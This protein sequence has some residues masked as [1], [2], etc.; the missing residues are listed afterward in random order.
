MRTKRWEGGCRGIAAWLLLAVVLALSAGCAPP[1]YEAYRA[2]RVERSP[3]QTS[4]PAADSRP[5]SAPVVREKILRDVVVGRTEAAA[6]TVVGS[7]GSAQPQLSAALNTLFVRS[8]AGVAL[9]NQPLQFGRPFRSGEIA[10]CPQLTLDGEPIATQADVKTRYDDGSVRFSVVSA[11]LPSV[12]ER[13][14]TLGFV[15]APCSQPSTANA[16]E[17]LGE[18]YDFDAIVELNAGSA[19]VVSARDL[20]LKKKFSLWT[21]G[22]VVTTAIIA[23]HAGKSADLGTDAHKS[24][25]P[26]FE[27]QFWPSLQ[28]VRTRVVMEVADVEKIQ[29]QHYVVSIRLGYRRPREA[30]RSDSVEHA[31]MTRWTKVFWNGA[32]PADLDIDY[33]VGYLASTQ[34]IPNYDASIRLSPST[35]SAIVSGWQKAK[36]DIYEPGMWTRA[37]HTTG[38]RADIGPYP[39]W[40]VAWLYDGSAALREVALGQADLAGAWPVHLRE[41]SSDKRLVRG[42]GDR[43]LGM[44]VSGYARPTLTM[45]D[46]RY[47]WTARE[48]RANVVGKTDSGGWHADVA[49]QPQPFFLP[50]LLTGEHFYLEQMQFWAGFTLLDSGWGGYGRSCTS[51]S[52]ST[53]YMGF[54]EQ[55]QARATAWALRMLAE[56]AWATP[57]HDGGY[58]DYLRTAY[59]D[60]VTRLEGRRGVVRGTNKDRADWQWAKSKGD[61]SDGALSTHNPLHYWGT[62]NQAYGSNASVKRYEATWQYGFI[63]YALNRGVELG[64][65]AT[66]LREWF[67]HFFVS[68]ATEKGEIPY[69]LSD[70]TLPVID[71]DTD[72][73]YQDWSQVH[74][75]YRDYDGAKS[76]PPNTKPDSNSKNSLDQ[77]Y[78]TVALTAL[79]S[80]SGTPGSALAWDGF[81][82]AHYEAWGWG[83]DPKWAILP[84]G[85][86]EKAKSAMEPRSSG[87]TATAGPL[88]V[89]QATVGA[90][91]QLPPWATTLPLHQWYEIPG[92]ELQRSDAWTS[93]KGSKGGSK[94][95]IL[96]FSGGAIKMS[97]SELFIAGGGH[98][99]YS[100]NEVFSIVLGTE[101]PKWIRRIDP[102][103]APPLPDK[104]IPYYEDGRPASRHT[105]W[106]LQFIDQR[107]ILVFFGAPALWA[108]NGR[109]EDVVDAFDPANNDYL[110]AGT[111]P[112]YPGIANYAT[113]MAK[114]AQGNV[115]VHILR[116]GELVRWNQRS[117]TWTSF[118]KK[119]QYQYETAYAIDTRRNRMVRMANGK[120][121]AAYF[122]LTQDATRVDIVVKGA[123]AEQVGGAGQLVYD[124]GADVFWFWKR[125]D[126]QLYRI[127]A[128]TWEATMQPVS[129]KMPDNT[130]VSSIH[131]TYG[132]F[133]YASELRGLVFMRDHTSNVYFIRTSR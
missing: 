69:H 78:A 45:A 35:R 19:G 14:S 54:G 90:P 77:G 98:T 79:A 28:L 32:P 87:Q 122:D 121:P 130:R 82:K 61:C 115:Y 11:I 7:P 75:E 37:M 93:Y 83:R 57:E 120:T 76:W 26:S 91:R 85:I 133:N 30:Y 112:G 16:G 44:P 48:D 20:V 80:T 114:D 127:D 102:S 24:V 55:Q 50:Y 18:E 3:T 40:M 68:A 63:M 65:P 118:G 89:A 13:G 31:Y 59:E 25:R 62:G 9:Q 41:G 5:A 49:H 119:G 47:E 106:T 108:R 109:T 46:L 94:A 74:A 60:V 39:K 128:E 107:N 67:A 52:V 23:D 12:S 105:Y 99:D 129:G 72:G 51:R 84:R 1:W 111:L 104:N 125:G 101:H 117:N 88:P 4:A 95:G 103:V 6:P 33:N 123:A 66:A 29:N 92:T 2:D 8:S 38:G 17:L 110:P 10:N 58:R 86:K 96:A 21:S 131:N 53:S 64:L 73:F 27:V 56:A 71:A 100:G 124:T 116:T 22:P 15:D 113:G 97:G 70:Y 42:K 132:R 81:A 34:A 126:S 43:A 36:K